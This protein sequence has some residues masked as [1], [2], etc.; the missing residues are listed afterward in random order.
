MTEFLYS[1]KRLLKFVTF[2]SK[3]DFK[4]AFLFVTTTILITGILFSILS[5]N[6]FWY[7]YCNSLYA[8]LFLVLLLSSDLHSKNF[9]I[10]SKSFVIIILVF[11]LLKQKFLLPGT[12]D[13]LPACC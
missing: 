6:L 1:A 7:R 10:K 4:I 9:L 3:L 8:D 2:H 5:S 13:A 11:G 12:L